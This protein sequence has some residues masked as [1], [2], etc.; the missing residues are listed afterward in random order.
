[1]MNEA[2]MLN[3][4]KN[5]FS[6]KYLAE[7]RG[8]TVFDTKDGYE[9]FGEYAISK[10]DNRFVVTKQNTDLE[11]SFF[12]LRNAVLWTTLY[13]RDKVS[14]ARRVAELDMILEGSLFNVEASLKMLKK[15]KS[16]DDIGIYAAKLSD[17]KAKVSLVNEQLAVFERDVR[18]WQYR[19]YKSLSS[20]TNKL[21]K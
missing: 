6:D 5:M 21:G 14:D 2:H 15:V 4:L 12:N 20:G 13:K 9:L 11:K 17:S 1:M 3:V 7:L 10:R 18:S 19:K 8:V 16:N